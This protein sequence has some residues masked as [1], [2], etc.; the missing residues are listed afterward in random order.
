MH[1]LIRDELSVIIPLCNKSETIE[2]AVRSVLNQNT[3]PNSIIIIDGRSE[4]EKVQQSDDIQFKHSIIKLVDHEIC[5]VSSARNRG[6]M[7]SETDYIAFLGPDDQ[8]LPD[9]TSNLWKVITKNREADFYSIPYL[10]DSPKGKV[11][12]T[13]ELPKNF[14]GT[15]SNFVK[16]YSDGAGIIHSSSVCFRRSFFLKTGG[17]PEGLK[18]DV[19]TYMWLKAGLSGSCAVINTRTVVL[20]K[21]EIGGLDTVKG[22]VPYHVSYFPDHMGE[23]SVEERKEIKYF[24]KKNIFLLWAAAKIENDRIQ[25]K[26]LRSAMYKIKKIKWLILLFSELIPARLFKLIRSRHIKRM[27][28]S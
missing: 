17:F 16:T 12:P 28:K 10:I 18:T 27:L 15:V 25:K 6:V 7:E 20:Y 8:W 19:D 5:D 9:H 23:Y 11:N 4:A 2:Q 13:V 26:Y 24:L 3:L 21:D 14:N 22:N 1:S